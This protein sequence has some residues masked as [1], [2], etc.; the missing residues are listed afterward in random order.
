MKV[1]KDLI[2]ERHLNYL[3]EHHYHI[4][5]I[6]ASPISRSIKVK[7][8]QGEFLLKRL[9]PE[10]EKRWSLLREIAEYCSKKKRKQYIPIPVPTKKGQISFAAMH[11]KYILLPWINGD[12]IS[13]TRSKDWRRTARALAEMHQGTGGFVPSRTGRA[14]DHIGNWSLIWTNL[15]EQIDE[16]D[17]S[18]SADPIDQAWKRQRSYTAGMLE[19]SL[20]YLEKVGGDALCQELRREGAVCHGNIRTRHVLRDEDKRIHFLSWDQAVLDIRCRD[21]AHLLNYAFR[22][23]GN[24]EI[25]S[26]VLHGYQQ[27]TPLK[28]PEYALIYT[29]LLF[30]DSM[31]RRVDQVY[32]QRQF[33][34]QQ[35]VKRF[36]SSARKEEVKTKLLKEF[37][38]IVKKEFAITIP[39]VDWLFSNRA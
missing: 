7:T 1:T 37:P 12:P 29:R 33:S 21:I 16:Y 2:D 27:V 10:G 22:K 4:R 9:R 23:T 31:I 24:S 5:L 17:V 26:T 25:I 15:Y 11:G 28:E 30:P 19:T 20:K 35:A 13:F 6:A 34:P 8:E 38:C 36:A 18:S 3:L 39:E 32:R 14:F